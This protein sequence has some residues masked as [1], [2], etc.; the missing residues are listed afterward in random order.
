MSVHDRYY[1]TLNKL[2]LVHNNS[3]LGIDHIS[4]APFTKYTHT[5]TIHMY[6]RKFD[7]TQMHTCTRTHARTH[8]HAHAHARTHKHTRTRISSMDTCDNSQISVTSQICKSLSHLCKRIRTRAC[9]P[10]RCVHAF[11]TCNTALIRLSQVLCAA[12]L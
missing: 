3:C 1:C 10:A 5:H 7:R 8:T 2:A 4:R 12:T 9:T 6:A 11:V